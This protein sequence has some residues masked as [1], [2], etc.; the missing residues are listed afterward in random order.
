M[1]EKKE[2]ETGVLVLVKDEVSGSLSYS[3]T[4]TVTV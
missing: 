2:R 4:I 1:I 3:E